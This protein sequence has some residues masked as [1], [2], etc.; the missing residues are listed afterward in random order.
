MLEDILA[1]LRDAFGLLLQGFLAMTL[2]LVI[3][4]IA[5]A[6]LPATV[7]AALP[8]LEPTLR[9]AVTSWVAALGVAAVVALG[10]LLGAARSGLPRTHYLS[11]SRRLT[12]I[13][14]IQ[15]LWLLVPVAVV[16]GLLWLLGDLVQPTIREYAQ[17]RSE[18]PWRHPPTLE[19]AIGL[20]LHGSVLTISATWL[21]PPV[22]VLRTDGRVR[23]VRPAA[24]RMLQRI[25]SLEWF[26][27]ATLLV[28]V[29]LS[30]LFETSA[31]A[32]I[33][34]MLL[35]PSIT[36]VAIQRS[37]DAFRRASTGNFPLIWR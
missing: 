17:L 32:G 6:Q 15:G 35:W 27:V 10:T 28:V 34:L 11:G 26:L 16:A 31:L 25:A 2:P 19:I 1:T 36:V 13:W 7:Y 24:R 22:A 29:A 18:A 12:T 3:L 9:V 8:D 33:L 4:A 14:F 23:D 5:V 37:S 20:L 21:W 30:L